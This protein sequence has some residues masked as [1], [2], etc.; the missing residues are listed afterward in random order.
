M[1]TRNAGI[2]PAGGALQ[3]WK[4][5]LVALLGVATA[6]FSRERPAGPDPADAQRRAHG[7]NRGENTMVGEAYLRLKAFQRI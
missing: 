7:E 1:T 6:E 5:V 2:G 4:I 3:S